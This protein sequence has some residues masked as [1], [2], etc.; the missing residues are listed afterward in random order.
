MAIQALHN[1][2]GHVSG[3]CYI[4]SVQIVFRIISHKC[5]IRDKLMQ[6]TIVTC[7]DSK[8][9]LPMLQI[10]YTK[11]LLKFYVQLSFKWQTSVVMPPIWV[12]G[13]TWT[14][15]NCH[16]WNV[17][18]RSRHLFPM[19]CSILNQNS[20]WYFSISVPLQYLKVSIGEIVYR[21]VNLKP[22]ELPHNICATI[23]PLKFFR[24]I[25]CHSMDVD[26]V[27]ACL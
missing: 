6:I 7:W 21:I 5:F 12:M 15:D 2:T 11:C 1:R 25:R 23:Y 24:C 10:E 17:P 20:L 9:F 19:F 27:Q 16:T 3:M 4:Y 22:V 14:V 26:K 13:C 18:F 8:I